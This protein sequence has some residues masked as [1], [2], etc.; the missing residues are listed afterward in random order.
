MASQWD[1]G[2]LAHRNIDTNGKTVTN[3][4]G[5][6]I[7][8][9][10]GWDGNTVTPGITGTVGSITGGGNF[11]TVGGIFGAVAADSIA[12]GDVNTDASSSGSN[13]G[14]VFIRAVQRHDE[15]PPQLAPGRMAAAMVTGGN[16]VELWA[17]G[18]LTVGSG[19]INASGGYGYSGLRLVT[20]VVT[21]AKWTSLP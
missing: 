1:L 17:N 15:C 8:L 6:A 11:T 14:D 3:T 5:G 9:V 18:D 4:Y 13:G 19:G 12:L 16:G 10:A 21:A 2:L 7:Y 20:P